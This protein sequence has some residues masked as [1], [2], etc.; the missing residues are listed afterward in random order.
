MLLHL[1]ALEGPR[2]AMHQVLLRW[3]TSPDALLEL[4]LQLEAGRFRNRRRMRI[5][6]RTRVRRKR[7]RRKMMR[8]RRMRKRKRKARVTILLQG[9]KSGSRQG[10]DSLRSSSSRILSLNLSLN[11][12]P[13]EELLRQL[14]ENNLVENRGEDERCND[15]CPKSK[16]LCFFLIDY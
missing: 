13:S 8:R 16:V 11:P 2:D 1:L 3:L 9:L 10:L 14:V 6:A 12:N 5:Q 15:R 7:K 4:L